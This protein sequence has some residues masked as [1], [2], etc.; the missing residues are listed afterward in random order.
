MQPRRFFQELPVELS[1]D[2]LMAKMDTMLTYMDNA[3]EAQVELD[4][5]KKKIQGEIKVYEK[6][7]ADLRKQLNSGTEKQQVEVEERHDWKTKSVF[8][9]RLDTGEE[10]TRRAMTKEELQTHLR[11]EEEAEKEE[12]EVWGLDGQKVEVESTPDQD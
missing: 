9:V 5:Q 7:I 3:D 1:E 11:L 8:V 6:D 4:I 10:I 2:A 12:A